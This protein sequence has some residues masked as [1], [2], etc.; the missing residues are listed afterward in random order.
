MRQR[1]FSAPVW[2][3]ARKL[4]YGVFVCVSLRVP[5]R[6]IAVA[7]VVEVSSKQVERTGTVRVK[8]KPIWACVF[9]HAPPLQ[10]F[11]E[12]LMRSTRNRLQTCGD[13]FT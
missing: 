2:I 7:V 3:A 1:L 6:Y 8:V 9:V 12:M 4:V 11:C 5:V 10:E 13:L